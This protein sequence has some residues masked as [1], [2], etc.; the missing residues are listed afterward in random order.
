MVTLLLSLRP[1]F[2]GLAFKLEQGKFG[3][4]TYMR[5]YQGSIEVGETI[6]S[7]ADSSKVRVPKLVRMH[8]ADMEEVQSAKA[9]DIVAMFG[10]DCRSGTTFTNGKV[11]QSMT[12]MFVPDPVVVVP[13]DPLPVYL[14][15]PSCVVII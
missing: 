14:L 13:S 7:M 9:G 15:I 11:K 2:V 5:L 4:L 12:S 1:Q 8:S 3:Q 6:H 10:V